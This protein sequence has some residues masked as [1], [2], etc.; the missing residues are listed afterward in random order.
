SLLPTFEGIVSEATAGNVTKMVSQVIQRALIYQA[1]KR[2]GDAANFI[3]R[4]TDAIIS[5]LGLGGSA[6]SFRDAVLNAAAGYADQ[7]VRSFINGIFG[8]TDKIVTVTVISPKMSSFGGALGD[9]EINFDDVKK[10]NDWRDNTRLS[11]ELTYLYTMRIP[12]ANRVIHT[13]YIAG[14]VGQELHGAIWNPQKDEKATVFVDANRVELSG[15][16]ALTRKLWEASKGNDQDGA[17]FM[18]PLRATYSMRMQSNPYRRAI[19]LGVP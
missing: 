5:G 15:G 6:S 1:H 8:A 4:G 11:I 16:N 10:G 14:Q 2:I 3:R 17:V 12:F 9:K 7:G 13:A 19:A 18:I